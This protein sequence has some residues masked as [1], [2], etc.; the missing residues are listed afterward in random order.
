MSSMCCAKPVK[1]QIKSLKFLNGLKTVTKTDFHVH[2]APQGW[3]EGM[4]LYD[5]KK[6]WFPAENV[7]EVTTDH[8]RRR[9]VREQ[10]QISQTTSQNTQSWLQLTY[11]KSTSGN[12][13]PS[14]SSSLPNSFLSLFDAFFINM[15]KTDCSRL[16]ETVWQTTPSGVWPFLLKREVGAN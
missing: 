11:P 12:R 3:Y 8:Q 4:R 2:S 16:H 1:V 15:Q 5:G 10:Y 14:Y 13:Y 9:N 6:G 7:L